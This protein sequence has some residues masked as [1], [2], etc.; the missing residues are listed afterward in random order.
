MNRKIVNIPSVVI[1]IILVLGSAAILIFGMK[2]SSDAANVNI[3]RAG[4]KLA[5][6]PLSEDT[7]FLIEDAGMVIEIS[8]GKAFISESSCRCKT[9]QS[10]GKLSKSGQT[11]I[12]LPAQVRIELDGEGDLDATL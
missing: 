5:S 6:L 7:T 11:A 1:C 9:C 2:K 10:F 12:C 3:Y 4:E 8:E